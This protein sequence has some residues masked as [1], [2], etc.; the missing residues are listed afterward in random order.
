LIGERFGI[1]SFIEI[2]PPHTLPRTSSGKLSRSKAREQFLSRHDPAILKR[3]WVRPSTLKYVVA[4]ST[5]AIGVELQ[6][7]RL[8]G[9][10]RLSLWSGAN[11]ITVWGLF[12]LW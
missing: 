3:K 12:R 2:V 1:D 5:L 7:E 6:L 9:T 8:L 4:I 11:E 10:L